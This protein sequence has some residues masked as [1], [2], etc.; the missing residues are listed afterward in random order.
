MV[1]MMHIVSMSLSRA[2]FTP[3]EPYQAVYIAIYVDETNGYQSLNTPGRRPEC[4]S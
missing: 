2:H 4:C 3:R 1:S